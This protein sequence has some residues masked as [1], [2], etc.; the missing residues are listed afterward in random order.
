[1]RKKNNKKYTRNPFDLTK[2]I[3]GESQLVFDNLP[4]TIKPANIIPVENLV[5]KESKVFTEL[6]TVKYYLE[7]F[8]DNPHRIASAVGIDVARAK[9]LIADVYN[10]I[11]SI[12]NQSSAEQRR[13]IKLRNVAIIDTLI[14][15]AYTYLEGERGK[16]SVSEFKQ[17]SEVILKALSNKAKL[18]GIGD[19]LIFEQLNIQNNINVTQGQKSIEIEKQKRELLDHLHNVVKEQSLDDI[20]IID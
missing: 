18:Y 13:R 15:N 16:I 5:D 6:L 17:L 7:R 14:E 11:Y 8:G 12:D 20:D 3:E 10:I 2:K 19:K 4:K 1:M 9:K